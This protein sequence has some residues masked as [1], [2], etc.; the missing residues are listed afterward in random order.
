[1]EKAEFFDLPHLTWVDV[2][3]VRPSAMSVLLAS[4]HD[5]SSATTT[6]QATN[7]LPTVARSGPQLATGGLHPAQDLARRKVGLNYESTHVTAAA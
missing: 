4:A 6:V 2:R 7:R 5:T 3:D 1:M